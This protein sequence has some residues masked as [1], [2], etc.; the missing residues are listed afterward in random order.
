MSSIYQRKGMN[1]PR[2]Q[3]TSL[4]IKD[5]SQDQV[6]AFYGTLLKLQEKLPPKALRAN[7]IV[8]FAAGDG[9]MELHFLPDTFLAKPEE[10]RH[11]CLEVDDL[12]DY[13]K[14]VA[15]AGYPII[16][17]GPILHRP[18]FFTLDPNNNRVEFTTIEGNYQDE[19]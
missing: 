14:R 8:W 2:L 16:E 18:R 7:G 12:E 4:P 5:G 10:G 9:E 6:R 1:L 11:I 15:E 13:R 3:H 19:E 17:A